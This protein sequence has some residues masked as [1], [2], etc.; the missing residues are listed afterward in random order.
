MVT[1]DENKR[2]INLKRH[3]IDLAD[4]ERVFDFPMLTREDDRENYGEQRLCSLG[5]LHGRVVFLVWTERQ[6][7]PRAIS[8][9]Y[10]DKDE[11]RQY[12]KAAY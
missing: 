4:C 7:G 5:L 2:S 10:G 6:D 1:W 9:R 8:C 3:G 12:F 11:T